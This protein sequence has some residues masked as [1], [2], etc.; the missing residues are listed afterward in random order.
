V[1]AEPA[2]PRPLADAL[3]RPF[4]SIAQP[5]GLGPIV[6][7]HSPLLSESPTATSAPPETVGGS[8]TRAPISSRDVRQLA[9]AP[10]RLREAFVLNELLKPPVALRGRDRRL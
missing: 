6:L 5:H 3:A 2:A 8:V 9:S 4:P 7:P 1:R 10:A